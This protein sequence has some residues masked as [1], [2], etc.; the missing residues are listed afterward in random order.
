MKKTFIIA[1]A[2]INH[3]GSIHLAKK[4]IN[5]SKKAG[6]DAV[7]FQTFKA[8]N[9]ISMY[10]KKLSYQKKKNSDKQSQLDMLQ[11]YELSK[12]NFIELKKYCEKKKIIFMSTPKDIESASFLNSINMDIFKIGSGEANNYE[13]IKKIYKFNKQTIVSTGMCSLT[14]VKKIKNIFSKKKDQLTILHC[15]SLYPCSIEDCNLL[16]IKFIK[17]K[18]KVR[19]GF[20]DHTIGIDASIHAVA[21]GAEVIE[22]HITLNKDMK[23]PDHKA[24]LEEKEFK[25]MVKRIRVLEKLL[26]NEKKEPTLLEKRNIKLIR[27][28]LVYNK[29]FLKGEKI[30]KNDIGIKRPMLGLE[31]DQKKKIIGKKLNQ[32]VFIDQPILSKHLN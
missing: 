7:K 4:L 32:A 21:L 24:S 13:L 9:V 8:K 16:S 11:S 3:N 22:K 19:V 6:A 14:E 30:K 28:G 1:E 18:L 2:G 15:T 31:P 20:S 5:I 25:L 26:G 10:A 29:N 12:R 23:G 27:R 17:D